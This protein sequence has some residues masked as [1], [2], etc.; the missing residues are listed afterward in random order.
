MILL[1]APNSLLMLSSESS[2]YATWIR[3]FL[4]SLTAAKST[5]PLRVFPVKTENPLEMSSLNTA[6][7]RRNSYV[8]SLKI[9]NF[10]F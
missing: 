8:N 9:G 5:S 4:P 10:S 6:F 3:H 1:Y 7:F 2:R